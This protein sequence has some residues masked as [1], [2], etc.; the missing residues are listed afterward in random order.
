MARQSLEKPQTSPN[1]FQ[2]TIPAPQEDRTV[3]ATHICADIKRAGWLVAGIR[4]QGAAPPPIVTLIN[5]WLQ[6]LALMVCAIQPTH[7]VVADGHP[8][9]PYLLLVVVG[10]SGN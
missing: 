2:L 3:A 8:P 9:A 1:W 4:N 5:C 10:T 6:K 7:S